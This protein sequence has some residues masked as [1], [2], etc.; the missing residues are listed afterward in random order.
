MIPVIGCK[1]EL[2]LIESLA[3]LQYTLSSE[4]LERLDKVSRI[5]LGFPHDF[6]NTE[7]VKTVIYAGRNDSIDNHRK[8]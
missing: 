3:C 4:H 2:Q 7:G 5:E 6:L 8:K 1:N